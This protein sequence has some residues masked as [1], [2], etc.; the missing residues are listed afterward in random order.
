M[1]DLCPPDGQSIVW[2]ARLLG[3]PVRCRVAGSDFFDALLAKDV[4]EKPLGVFLFGGTQGVADTASLH[5]V[6]VRALVG[7]HS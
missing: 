7:H 5:R 3:I 4:A 6:T 1:S 2:I